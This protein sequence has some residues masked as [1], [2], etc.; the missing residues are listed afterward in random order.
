MAMYSCAPKIVDYRLPPD[1]GI[2]K[3]AMLMHS[4][5]FNKKL[6]KLE[7]VGTADIAADRTNSNVS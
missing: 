3:L 6:A 1:L 4:N 7:L 5:I 2:E